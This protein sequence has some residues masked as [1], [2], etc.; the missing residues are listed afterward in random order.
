MGRTDCAGAHRGII[1]KGSDM[2][3]RIFGRLRRGFAWMLTAACLLGLLAVPAAA[4]IE[5][6]YLSELRVCVAATWE[7]AAETLRAAGYEVIEQDLNEGTGDGVTAVCL[8]YR[9]TTDPTNALTDIAMLNMNRTF[10]YTDAAAIERLCGE[11]LDEAVR[12]VQTAVAELQAAY[13]KGSRTARWAY[14]VL[15][16]FRDTETNRDLG[17]LLFTDAGD[18]TVR[19]VLTDGNLTV[20]TLLFTMLYI[21]NGEA[22]GKALVTVLNGAETPATKTAD[23]A[24]VAQA[25]LANW[26][27]VRGPL[28]AYLDAPVQWDAESDRIAA[29]M[30]RLNDR[31][32][33][34]YLQGGSYAAMAGETLTALF[35]RDGLS[36]DTLSAVVSAMTPGQRAVAPYLS[37]DLLLFA[38]YDTEETAK[39][40]DTEPSDTEETAEARTF[41]VRLLAESEPERVPLSA[42]L[43]AF[44]SGKGG[45]ALTEDALS[46]SG[47]GLDLG[48]LW[49]DEDIFSEHFVWMISVIYNLLF[50]VTAQVGSDVVF[51][52]R[53]T[54]NEYN[55]EKFMW[56]RY[57]VRAR[58]SDAV[59]CARALTGLPV[60]D[61]AAVSK[62]SAGALASIRSLYA[63]ETLRSETLPRYSLIPGTAL[64]LRKDK[65]YTA[66][67]AVLQDV[68][69]SAVT[70]DDSGE[71]LPLAGAAGAYADLNGWCGSQWSALYTTKDPKAGKPIY[72]KNFCALADQEQSALDRNVVRAFSSRLSYNLNWYA[73]EDRLGGLYLY[74]DRVQ[75]Y[76]ERTTTVF[77]RLDLCLAIGGAS[78][79]GIIIGAVAVYVGYE[80][81]RKQNEDKQ[82]KEEN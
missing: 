56:N 71:T 53:D 8:G 2:V 47:Q 68:T 1:R 80:T 29:Y 78:A 67:S 66:Y 36:A 48:W 12:A 32:L 49:S 69:A 60:S 46:Y 70:V 21:G 14:D 50:R 9:T 27:T 13:G 45:L 18:V 7:E 38:G 77:S 79:G 37:P 55:T 51:P 17:E 11:T 74:F 42:G 40:T 57:V 76:G 16:I 58:E 39:D 15:N 10:G 62:L 24:R 34:N 65:G 75:D 6:Q 5:R 3:K 23:A 25:M 54:R 20:V 63:G 61:I 28:Q 52:E 44:L 35:T 4:D 41:G 33:S 19:R 82:K 22:S 59:V 81:R 72:A 31:E 43:Q 30:E 26:D 64:Q 73:N